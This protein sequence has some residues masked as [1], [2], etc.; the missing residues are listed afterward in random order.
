MTFAD[1]DVV[2]KSSMESTERAEA[3]RVAGSM[4]GWGVRL[5]AIGGG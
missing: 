5:P 2:L 4:G 1:S 3:D